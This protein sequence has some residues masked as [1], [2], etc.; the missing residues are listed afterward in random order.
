ML[1]FLIMHE[2][3]LASLFSFLQVAAGLWFNN[4]R[5][6]RLRSVS[7]INSVASNF[8]SQLALHYNVKKLFTR[9]LCQ[10]FSSALQDNV[11]R[12]SYCRV[13]LRIRLHQIIMIRQFGIYSALVAHGILVYALLSCVFCALRGRK[14]RA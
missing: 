12:V 6:C 3:L 4:C 13:N 8:W 7:R 11:S 9:K 5:A 14:W 10:T 2:H 1:I